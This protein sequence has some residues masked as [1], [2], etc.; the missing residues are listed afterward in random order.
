MTPKLLGL[1]CDPIDGSSL[2]LENPTYDDIGNIVSGKLI[3]ECGRTYEIKAGIPR[4]VESIA[5]A[6]VESFGDEWNYFNFDTFK[7]NWLTHTIKNTFGSVEAFK[8]KIVVD[9]GAGSGMQT[10]WISR[11]GAD[12]VIALELSHSVDGVMKRN[13]QDC[14]N[15]D[16]I[17]CSIDAPPIKINTINGIVMC[18][19]VIQHT[20]SVEE[21]A[22][23]LWKIVGDGGEF[24][25]NC[26]PK[27]DLGII[28]KARLAIYNTIRAVLS[29]QSFKVI[30]GYAKFMSLL[31]FIPVLGWVGEK[32]FLM[33]RG[34]V[35]EGPNWVKRA[36]KLGVLNTFD[37]YGS[38]TYQ[39]LKSEDEI[40]NLVEKLQPNSEKVLNADRYFF[41]P[42]PIGIALRLLK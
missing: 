27:N 24:V 7:D 40:R 11:A 19:N 28:R 9:A 10:Y 15:V 3:S 26:Y 39:H 17:Q 33:V 29:Q 25:F 5:T 38:H 42:Q 18:H 8:G 1:L 2:F 32:S 30:L 12:H 13:L 41:R 36:Y 34:D 20:R 35:P 21:T 22:N 31:R 23:A 14:K 4:F 16:I 6:D 37:C